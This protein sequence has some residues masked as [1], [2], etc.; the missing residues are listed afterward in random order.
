MKK[1]FRCI[2]NWLFTRKY[3]F[4]KLSD[5]WYVYNTCID[6]KRIGT[7]NFFIKYN[8]TWYDDIPNGWKKA[9]GKQLSKEIKKAGMPFIKQGKKWEDILS[10]QQIKEKWGELCL[11]ASAIEPIRE[12][13]DKYE[14]ISIGYCFHCGKPARYVTQGWV[15]FYCEK[16]FEKFDC[17]KYLDHSKV[18]L[19]GEEL[20]KH[21]DECRLTK[22]DVPEY[23]TYE[24]KLLDTTS[25]KDKNECQNKYNELVEKE[26]DDEYYVIVSD[27][28]IEHKK[29]IKHKVNL[30]E[31]YNIDF[32][33]LWGLK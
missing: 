29:Q 5:D 30:K 12:I 27:C 24:F 16:C 33:S 26:D 22:K 15:E 32:E 9:F 14:T 20:Q 19:S 28:I 1:L 23:Y 10:F 11:Y 17:W 4:W 18:P 7:K 13:L 2:K 6:D 31:K 25:F 8:F 3:P 21:K